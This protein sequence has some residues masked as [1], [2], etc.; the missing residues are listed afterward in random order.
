MKILITF[1]LAGCSIL[2]AGYLLPQPFMPCDEIGIT[3]DP[4]AP[5]NPAGEPYLND[6][7]F[8]WRDDL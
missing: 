6:N 2:W 3:T 4:D 5:I 8:D 1:I 7:E